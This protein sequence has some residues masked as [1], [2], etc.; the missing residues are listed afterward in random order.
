MLLQRFLCCTNLKADLHKK[1]EEGGRHLSDFQS[2]I[3]DATEMTENLFNE[4]Q[5]PY[6]TA[7]I[8]N[9]LGTMAEVYALIVQATRNQV[10]KMSHKK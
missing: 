5:K 2:F 9:L 6:K 10:K 4:R 8:Y 7:N 3:S 1:E